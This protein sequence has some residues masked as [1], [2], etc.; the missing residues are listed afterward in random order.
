MNLNDLVVRY[1]EKIGE[2][3]SGD[4]LLKRYNPWDTKAVDNL[5]K[6]FKWALDK[7]SKDFSWLNI[8]KELLGLK[9]DSKPN[10]HFGIPNH[11]HGDIENGTFYLCMI[12][13][14]IAIKDPIVRS[15]DGL[16]TYVE[17]EETKTSKDPSL[18]V[19]ELNESELKEF[20]K[21][22]VVNIEKTGSILLNELNCIKEEKIEIEGKE[23]SFEAE[24][25]YY[26]KNYFSP[27]CAIFLDKD[28]KSNEFGD[29]KNSLSEKE[30]AS[31]IEMSKSVVNLEAFPFRSKNPNF[32]QKNTTTFANEIVA[33]QSRVGMLSSRIIIWRI[34]RYIKN[35]DSVKPIFIFRKFKTA[36]LPSLQN[37]LMNDLE[38]T[39]DEVEELIA[40]LHQEFFYTIEKQDF[41]GEGGNTLITKGKK[42]HTYKNDVVI[43]ADDFYDIVKSALK[44]S[45]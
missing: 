30:W 40:L 38:Y 39:E 23:I 16:K 3:S 31:L 9:R 22:H 34:C 25:A 6:K 33:S 7:N 8:E 20:V 19:Q 1:G 36:W 14:N 12:N 42:S 28:K 5:V 10:I 15:V 29:L 18:H 4:E 41:F 17:R 11:V 21:K 32:T 37:V 2:I 26:L 27:I 44:K 45:N 13:P 43:E 24:D 35:Q